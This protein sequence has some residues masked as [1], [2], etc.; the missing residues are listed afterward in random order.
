MQSARVVGNRRWILVATLLA[1]FLTAMETTVVSTALPTVIGELQ[2]VQLYAWVF[3]AYLLTST[4]T[5][6]LYGRLADMIGRKPIFIVGVVIFLTGSVLCG[7]ATSMPLLILFRAVQ[8]LG[9]GAVQ[10]IVFTIVGDLFSMEERAR[11]QGFFSAVWGSSSLVGPALGAIITETIGWRWIFYINLPF[12]IAATAILIWAMH[13]GRAEGKHRIDY[14]GAAALTIGVTVTLLGLL[15][16]FSGGGIEWSY[17]FGGIAVLVLFVFIETRV[18]EP[19][20]PLILFRNPFIAIPCLIGLVIGLMQFGIPSY[21]PLFMQGVQFG[22]A[23]DAAK[24]LVAISGF[25]TVAAFLSPR[26]LIR[27]G[28]R[29]VALVGM[30]LNTVGAAILLAFRQETPLVLIFLSLA[31]IGFGLG[32]AANSTL[33]ASQNAVGWEQRGVV[34]ASVQFTRTMGGTIGV[35]VLGAVLNARLIPTLRAA[36][37]TDVNALLEPASRAGVSEQVLTVLR[38]GLAS[39]LLGVYAIML[40]VAVFGIFFALFIPAKISARKATGTAAVAQPG[41]SDD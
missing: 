20:L 22:T 15:G 2:G 27:F 23:G 16:G 14:L 36:G 38:G 19:V 17:F 28:F 5:V 30:L 40:V 41:G 3:S 26:L 7:S 29:A 24:V 8:G 9:A 32:F 31:V 6:P 10:P 25:W 1:T 21:V 34:T 35:A 13:E 37:A 12:G 11:V 39:S 18:P 33:L 4:A